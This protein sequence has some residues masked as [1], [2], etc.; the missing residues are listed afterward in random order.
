MAGIQACERMPMVNVTVIDMLS[1]IL[2]RTVVKIMREKYNIEIA[3]SGGDLKT[4][5][6]R[7]GN[8]G[9]VGEDEI[10][11]CLNALKKVKEE[12][13]ANESLRR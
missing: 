8:Y 10:N 2:P 12:L 5:L 9:N 4:K 13:Y 3:P 6:F 7:I 11:Q 1:A